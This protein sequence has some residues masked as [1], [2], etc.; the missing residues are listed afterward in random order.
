MLN[1]A[2]SVSWMKLPCFFVDKEGVMPS[3]CYTL[4]H[5]FM[6]PFYVLL[7]CLSLVPGSLLAQGIVFEK[8]SWADALK[9]AKKE[10]KLLFV[11]FDKPGCGSCGEVASIAFNSPL[12]REKFALNFISFRTDGTTGI[13]KEL[14]SKLEV[15]C[16]P[17]SIYLDTDEQSA[18]PVLRQHQP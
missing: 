12:M 6:K 7:I 3:D 10:N 1:R 13:G 15:E 16:T 17:S 11:H 14:S 9:K 8:G 2:C 18:G 4:V 5:P